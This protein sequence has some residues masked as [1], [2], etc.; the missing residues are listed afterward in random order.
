LRNPWA[1]DV[2][3]GVAEFYDKAIGDDSPAQT[4]VAKVI[5]AGLSAGLNTWFGIN[6]PIV[7]ALDAGQD[8]IFSGH[9]PVPISDTVKGSTSGA[10]TAVETIFTGRTK[11]IA[12][13]QK[14]ARAG[15]YGWLLRISSEA[16][17]GWS[18]GGGG[19]ERAI[20][21]GE[22]Y[23]DLGVPRIARASAFIASIPIVGH[24]GD[25]VGRGAANV[26]ERLTSDE[27]T[28]IPWKTEL[29]SDIFH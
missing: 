7:A 2:V 22:F 18:E 10:T 15:D 25:L 26:H 12:S 13:F 29:W 4:R 5:D 20:T 19:G 21:T 1:L 6:Y 8:K 9:K 27:Y 14:R 11:G 24:A 16:G 3:G 17:E 23:E 28:L